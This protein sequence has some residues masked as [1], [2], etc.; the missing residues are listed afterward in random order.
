LPLYTFARVGFGMTESPKTEKLKKVVP[1]KRLES[2]LG[3]LEK[4]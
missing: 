2:L 3:G 4:C 1:D